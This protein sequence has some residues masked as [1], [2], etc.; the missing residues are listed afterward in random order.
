MRETHV[1]I[2]KRFIDPNSKDE[3]IPIGPG[4]VISMH[5]HGAGITQAPL[6]IN[7]KPVIDDHHMLVG[8]ALKV[9]VCQVCRQIKQ[10]TA[11]FFTHDRIVNEGGSGAYPCFPIVDFVHVATLG[12]GNANKNVRGHYA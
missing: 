9:L 5:R 11:H 4:D 6:M 8:R 2:A 12:Q 1:R 10:H 3:R 7:Q